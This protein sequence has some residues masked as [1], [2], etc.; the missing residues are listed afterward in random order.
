M[1][2]S[3]GEYASVPCYE[4]YNHHYAV[5]LLGNASKL[6]FVGRQTYLDERDIMAHRHAP[7]WQAQMLPEADT[8]STV[9]VM[10]MFVEGN[11]NE[12]RRTFKWM[13][14]RLCPILRVSNIVFSK[15]YDDQHEQPRHTRLG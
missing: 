13:P 8:N 3:S 10:Q 11:G 5:S 1:N 15:F 14:K 2:Q 6:A 7:Q 12:H 9:P 4:Q